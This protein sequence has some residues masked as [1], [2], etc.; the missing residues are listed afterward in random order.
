[1]SEN[2]LEEIIAQI[3]P[4]DYP[5]TLDPDWDGACP[6]FQLRFTTSQGTLNLE[7]SCWRVS[8]G[9][10]HQDLHVS[11]D[12]P[13]SWQ[14]RVGHLVHRK[15]NK[16]EWYQPYRLIIGRARYAGVADE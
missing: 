15:L 5:Q 7:G 8:K 14:N 1:M 3:Q 12:V 9:H 13:I 4:L 16:Q 6:C 11:G 10:Q 2:E